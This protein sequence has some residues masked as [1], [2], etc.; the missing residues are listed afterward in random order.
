MTLAQ[1]LEG[2]TQSK[3]I[4]PVKRLNKV[5]GLAKNAIVAQL[6]YNKFNAIKPTKKMAEPKPMKKGSQEEGCQTRTAKIRDV[7]CLF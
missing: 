6:V 1:E 7:Y 5:V 3:Y 4:A 2:N